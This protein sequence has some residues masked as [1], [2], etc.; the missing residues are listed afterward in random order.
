MA[1]K[2][3]V[4]GDAPAKKELSN[5]SPSDIEDKSPVHSMHA[6]KTPPASRSTIVAVRV[7]RAVMEMRWTTWRS[8]R[9]N[10]ADALPK[11]WEPQA[12]EKDL[13]EGW[14]EKGYFT[15]VTFGGGSTME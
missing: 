12:V 1:L 15:P 10:R 6:K 4:R 3:A 11:S 5:L 2:P 8:R 13:Y 9:T 7:M 14:V